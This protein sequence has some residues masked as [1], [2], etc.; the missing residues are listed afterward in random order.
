[1]CRDMRQIVSTLVRWS[2]TYRITWNLSVAG[3][4]IGQVTGD[5][6]NGAVARFL[7]SCDQPSWPESRI[8]EILEK[9]KARKN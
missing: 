3:H 6:Q 9:H 4:D 7:G 1:M 8:S 5:T 2:Q